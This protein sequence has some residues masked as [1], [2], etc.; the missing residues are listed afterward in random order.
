MTTPTPQKSDEALH[1]EREWLRVTLSSIGDA[2]LTTDTE[3]RVRFLN[4][5]AQSLT[6]WTQEDAAGK[7]LDIVFRIVDEAARSTIENPATRALRDGTVVGLENHT[8]L[9]A[10]D[11]TERPIDNSAAP[12][13]NAKGEVAGVVLVFR[14]VSERRGQQAAIRISEVRYRRLFEAARDGILILDAT[15]LKIIDANPYMTELLGYSHDELLGKE[16][17]EIGLFKDEQASQ[18][19]YRELQDKGYIRY[20]NLPLESKTGKKAEVEFVSN[21]YRVDGR[22]VAQCNIRDI[23][24]R[25]RLEKKTLE[26]AAALAD[27]SRRKDEFLAMLSHELRNPLAPIANA[28][29]LLRLQKNEAPIQQQAR[30]IIELQVAQLIRL[31]DDL[32]EVSRITTGKVQLRL[33]RVVVNGIV[34]RAVESAHPLIDRHEHELTVALS[35]EPIWL[36]A[37]AARLDQV[38]VN[39]LTNAAKY[40]SDGGHI[41]LSVK[42]EGD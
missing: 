8:L 32:M 17:W 25:S 30:T 26:Q 1:E 20:E 24:E 22:E 10:R 42:Q 11:G 7:S 33:E 6:G 27:L 23:G 12:I 16:L 18:A 31:I 41:S 19:I 3:G 13:R 29:Q 35:P 5:V 34:G 21:R 15:T 14:D 4:P 9:V 37:D 2:V 36:Y 38:V 28:V 39:L 40:T